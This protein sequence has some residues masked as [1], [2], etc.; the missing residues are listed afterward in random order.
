MNS[1]RLENIKASIAELPPG[2]FRALTSWIADYE[3]EMWD[4]E[5]E[6]DLKLGKLDALVEAALQDINN[7]DFKDM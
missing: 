5:I 2:E 3:Q 4:V 1:S 7:G 6:E